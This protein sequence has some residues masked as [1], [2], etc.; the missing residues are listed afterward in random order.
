MLFSSE[1]YLEMDS[2]LMTEA[3]IFFSEFYRRIF[4]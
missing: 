3:T 4:F 2:S 1:F